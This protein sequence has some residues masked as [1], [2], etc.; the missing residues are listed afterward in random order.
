VRQARRQQR[1]GFTALFHKGCVMRRRL[2][3]A[4]VPLALALTAVCAQARPALAYRPF[5][6]T[7]AAVADQGEVEMEFQPA[8]RLREGSQTYLIAP[9]VVIN[10]GFAKTWELVVQGQLT[11]PLSSSEPTA[12]T[13]TA[14][15]LKHVLKEGSLQ[16]QTGPSV[17]TEFCVL[18]PDSHG[19]SGTG[20][21]WAGI[22][23]QRGDWGA[24]H[25][26]VQAAL[27]RDHH[28]DLFVG[29]IAEGPATWTLRPVVE[30]FF[31][32]E[33]GAA[34]TV[35]GL[36]GLIWQ[37]NDKLAFDIGVR[38]AKTSGHAVHEIRGGLTLSFAVAPRSSAPR[39]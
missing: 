13:G 36:V 15:L 16:D 10:Y 22:V 23:S 28:A 17:A 1:Y 26:T 4:V 18:L 20:F 6:G 7:D 21:S 30:V 34:Q 32:D 24:V 35:S 8:G 29:A 31:E 25:L 9:A 19:A 5:D 11:T 14:L 2:H 39:R 37:V 3:G 27:T 33:I 12:L 38:D